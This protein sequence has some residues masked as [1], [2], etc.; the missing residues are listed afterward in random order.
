MPKYSSISYHDLDL[1]RDVLEYQA[2]EV[3]SGDIKR[4]G[5]TATGKLEY[6][7]TEVKTPLG[8]FLNRVV[9]TGDYER[10]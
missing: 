5:F 6:D 2:A 10:E 9:A 7:V 8:S 3:W 4:M 1:S